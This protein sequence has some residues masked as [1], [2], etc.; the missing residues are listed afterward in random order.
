M[1]YRKIIFV[2]SFLVISSFL[3]NFST[4][5]AGATTVAEI[6]ALIQ[7]LLQQIAQL[8]KQLVETQGTPVSWC[9]D[10]NSN[11]RIGNSGLEITA[12]QTA[13]EKEGFLTEVS[14]DFDEKTAS[15]VVGF[16]EKYKEK[17]LTPLG[18][19]YGTGFV[20]K[21]TRTKL[22]LLYGCA[23]VTPP[24][25]P[26][27]PTPIPTPTTPISPPTT[28]TAYIKV[29]SPNGGENLTFGTPYQI[30][31]SQTGLENNKV[32]ILLKTY[33]KNYSPFGTQYLIAG[34]VSAS[35]RAY[36]WIPSQQTLDDYFGIVVPRYYYKIIIRTIETPVPTTEIRD[37]SDNYFSIVSVTQ[38]INS[39]PSSPTIYG[40]TSVVINA[41]NLFSAVS[42]D[43][44]GND[45]TYTFDWGDGTKDSK[46]FGSGYLYSVY[47][48]WSISG[49]YTIKVTADDNKGGTASNTYVVKVSQ[50]VN[51][52]PSTPTVSGPTSVM[53]NSSN[54]YAAVSTDPDG[55]DI[56]Y[57]FDWG[58]GTKDS[59]NFG[60]GY[61]YS[62]YHV[63][64]ASG[65]YTIT[66][67]VSDNKGGAASATYMV[68][69]GQPSI[70][71]LS[72]NGGEQLNG[73]QSYQISWSY[74]GNVYSQVDILL[75]GFD[76]DG[77]QIN[78]WKLIKA[79]A[80]TSQG[81]Y[82]WAPYGA[83]LYLPSG[84]STTP[85]KYKIKIREATDR[86][87]ALIDISDSYF[88]VI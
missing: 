44:D 35:Q 30:K 75:G 9:H 55:N 19:K 56:T 67:T 21:A 1:S 62:V 64:T 27:T 71:V 10:F 28:P 52:P 24:L 17:I 6:Q 23:I 66:V 65:I 3:F 57:T 86:A 25:T 47:H 73:N 85:S 12:L 84:F 61:G 45:I 72:P 51:N 41:N 48:S 53:V 22:N 5:T 77:N 26:I 58:D 33:D 59:K 46:N 29:I 32:D 82:Y 31:W 70:T 88:S 8:R 18:L 36:S 79:G 76:A 14:G 2:I 68:K 50:S 83:P 54:L 40:P 63:W 39:S 15:A 43:P 20:G 80:S 87:D 81:Y 78:D 60:S 4:P 74:T 37:E 13:L 16:Q 11:L 38:P 49:I 34:T 7:Q 42:T 69:V